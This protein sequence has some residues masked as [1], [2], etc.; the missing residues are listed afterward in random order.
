MN[1][2]PSC[3]Q[4]LSALLQRHISF[5]YMNLE[6]GYIFSFELLCLPGVGWPSVWGRGSVDRPQLV[7][8]IDK[9]NGVDWNCGK[10][11]M[12]DSRWGEPL[13]FGYRQSRQGECW[14]DRF[15]DRCQHLLQDLFQSLVRI[16]GE[17]DMAVRWKLPGRGWLHR[18][19]L[20]GNCWD[21]KILPDW[22][23]PQSLG[24]DFFSHINCDFT[25]GRVVQYPIWFPLV[26]GNW[27]L[28]HSTDDPK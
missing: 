16:W 1:P 6:V 7:W 19:S 23:A 15:R 10:E 3:L 14:D 24:L 27:N 17:W 26:L 8:S 11:A 18:D 2:K 20:A 12:M 25:S 21:S 28:S 4:S 5:W 13:C 9:L 22:L